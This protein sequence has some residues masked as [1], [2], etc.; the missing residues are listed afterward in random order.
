MKK[1]EHHAARVKAFTQSSLFGLGAGSFNRS[2]EQ[3]QPVSMKRR[4]CDRWILLN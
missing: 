4:A 1:S 2:A 3:L